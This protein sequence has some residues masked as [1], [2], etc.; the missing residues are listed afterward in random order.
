MPSRRQE[1]G[2]IVGAV[3]LANFSSL[4]SLTSPSHLSSPNNDRRL[5]ISGASSVERELHPPST[6]TAASV[7]QERT[8]ATSPARSRS[9]DGGAATSASAIVTPEKEGKKSVAKRKSTAATRG[10][11][12]RLR[13]VAFADM[14]SFQSQHASRDFN[15]D[16]DDDEDDIALFDEAP[17]CRRGGGISGRMIID[18]D[19]VDVEGGISA[20]PSDVKRRIYFDEEDE[21]GDNEADLCIDDFA[22]VRIVQKEEETL[23]YVASPPAGNANVQTSSSNDDPSHELLRL[24]FSDTQIIFPGSGGDTSSVRGQWLFRRR[25]R[26]NP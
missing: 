12:P 22:E 20:T 6:L 17:T 18:D 5:A 4:S 24:R 9:S 11:R 21:E 25:K 13:R 2:T 14:E 7:Q 1:T 26:W 10:N 3:A 16:D 15:A 19:D 23:I 8:S